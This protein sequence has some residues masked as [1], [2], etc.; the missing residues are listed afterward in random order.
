MKTAI[1][2]ALIAL[3]VSA[4]VAMG[5]TN[6]IV[7]APGPTVT[8]SKDCKRSVV[9]HQPIAARL[10]IVAHQLKCVVRRADA[11]AQCVQKLGEPPTVTAKFDHGPGKPGD[12][13]GVDKLRKYE[14]AIFNCASAKP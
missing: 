7:G 6:H 3:V 12:W 11:F 4:T 9:H 10:N 8:L 1:V 5:Q 2:A 14:L 13:T